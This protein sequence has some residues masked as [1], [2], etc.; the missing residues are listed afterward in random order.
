MQPYPNA[1][2]LADQEILAVSINSPTYQ[3]TMLNGKR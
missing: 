2:T 1:E 3:S